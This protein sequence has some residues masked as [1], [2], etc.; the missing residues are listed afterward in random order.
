MMRKAFF[1]LL[2]GILLLSACGNKVY[3]KYHHTPIAGWEKNDTLSFDIPKIEK[4]DKYSID[5]GL[6]INKSFPFMNLTLI[7][8]QTLYPGSKIFKDTI[9]AKLINKNGSPFGRGLGYYQY[10]FHV[11]EIELQRRDSL[12]ITVRHDMKHEI[13]PGISDVG[14]TMS[15]IK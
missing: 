1:I 4:P 10:S 11:R 2:T 3:D 13:L 14:I 12:H 5:L 6:R 8:E 15:A 7:V 9:N